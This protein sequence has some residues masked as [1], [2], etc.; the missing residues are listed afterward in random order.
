MQVYAPRSFRTSALGCLLL[1]LAAISCAPPP[2]DMSRRA[3][4]YSP[5]DYAAVLKRWTRKERLN[6][7]D[8]MDNVLTATATYES[9]DF[10]SAYVARYAADYQLTPPDKKQLLARSLAEAGEFHEFY[11]AFF[12]QNKDWAVLGDAEPA[13]VVHL[14]DDTGQRTEPAN[15]EK[16]RKP[17]AL[18]RT[19]FPYTNTWRTVY[20]ISFPASGPK[21]AAS[22][23]PAA[24][25]FGLEFS[26]VKGHTALTW[27]IEQ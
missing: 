14:I 13:W 25:S 4:D 18:E 24:Q 6:S 16:I 11:V 9:W 23:A 2:V 19:Y 12:A 21:G 17:G 20:R 22:I 8:E 7:L 15:L 3:R 5:E 10:R 1:G 27:E 26:G